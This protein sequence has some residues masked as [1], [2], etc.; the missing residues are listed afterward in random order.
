MRGERE[1]E[2]ERARPA[3]RI[4]L[5]DIS[6]SVSHWATVLVSHGAMSRLVVVSYIL[7]EEIFGK[8]WQILGILW[9]EEF[10]DENLILGGILG[11]ILVGK[12]WMGLFGLLL[13]NRGVTH[14]HNK[15]GLL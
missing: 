5:G 14:L 11:I 3:H 2:R 12:K 7:G 9:E 6:A 13:M 10:C 8:F 15:G 4:A 1:R